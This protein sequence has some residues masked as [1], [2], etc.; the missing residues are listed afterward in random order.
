VHRSLSAESGLPS[1]ADRSFSK[2]VIV[3]E[4]QFQ[5][6]TNQALPPTRPFCTLGIPICNAKT[7]NIEGTGGFFFIDTNQPGILY[8]LTARHVLFNPDKDENKLYRFR[9][10]SGE[11]Q[12]KVLL[13]G[14]AAF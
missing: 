12:K 5:R 1:I 2:T 10:G 9:N 7:A 6:S 11:A 3:H 8:L 4:S 13:M 14:E